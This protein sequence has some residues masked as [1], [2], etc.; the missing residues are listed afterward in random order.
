MTLRLDG[1]FAPLV[2]HRIG[3]STTN[4]QELHLGLDLTVPEVIDLQVEED[5]IFFPSFVVDVLLQQVAQ[6]SRAEVGGWRDGFCA[7]CRSHRHRQ[8]PPRRMTRSCT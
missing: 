6:G 7:T 1:T 2:G 5:S 8:E 3:T 4:D